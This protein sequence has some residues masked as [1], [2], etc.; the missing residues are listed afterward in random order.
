MAEVSMN[1]LQQQP[2]PGQPKAGGDYFLVSTECCTWYVSTAMARH[3]ET[4]LDRR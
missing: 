3:V 4:S 1:R 2:E